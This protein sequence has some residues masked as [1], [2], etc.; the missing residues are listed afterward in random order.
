MSFYRNL[1]IG[2]KIIFVVSLVLALGIGCL[3]VVINAEVKEAIRQDVRKI[4]EANTLRYKNFMTAGF[5]EVATL[6]LSSTR[7]LGIDYVEN[8]GGFCQRSL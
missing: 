2:T 6:G 7:K 4:L 8:R 1:K 3:T 5:D